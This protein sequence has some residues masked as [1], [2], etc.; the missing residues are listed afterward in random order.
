MEAKTD[1][2]DLA[3]TMEN[4]E[5]ANRMITSY[6][7]RKEVLDPS[8]VS[9]LNCQQKEELVRGLECLDND[10]FVTDILQS[11]IPD[12]ADSD[13]DIEIEVDDLDGTLQIKMYNFMLLA[14]RKQ[15]GND[16]QMSLKKLAIIYQNECK[17]RKSLMY[18]DAVNNDIINKEEH[19]MIAFC[20]RMTG[21]YEQ[22]L[23]HLE[24][25]INEYTHPKERRGYSWLNDLF[26]RQM[27]RK[28]KDTAM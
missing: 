15:E 27:K 12:D 10:H 5:D 23:K 4:E 21:N 26:Q 17:Y 25:L 6:L 2:F 18:F 7:L 20:Y 22:S 3:D 19:G 1:I 28:D 24:L 9:N 11:Y 14:L 13:E 16:V 8:V